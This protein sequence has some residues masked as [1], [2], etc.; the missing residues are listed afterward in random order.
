[1]KQRK[2]INY[3]NNADFYA[4]LIKY[5]QA[6]NENELAEIPNYVGTCIQMICERLSTKPNFIRYTFRDEMVGDGVENCISAINGFDPEKSNNPF[7]YFTQIAWNAFIRR[8]T[9]EQKQLYLKHKNMQ[10]LSIN[11]EYQL[12][13]EI[14]DDIIQKFEDK[15]RLTKPKKRD[16][17]KGIEI[18]AQEDECCE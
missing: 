16:T 3:V 14:G 10:M 15:N 13:S 8:I 5:K 9:R 1:M 6:R 4:A 18:F 12:T 7:S 17:I 2:P 11:D